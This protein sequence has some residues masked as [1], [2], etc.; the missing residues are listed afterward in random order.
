MAPRHKSFHHK[1]R[2]GCV[3]CKARH[4]KCD[5]GRPGCLRCRKSNRRCGG[6]DLPK[7]WIFE[8]Y[9][10]ND[11]TDGKRQEQ[12]R[13]PKNTLGDSPSTTGARPGEDLALGSPGYVQYLLK[14]YSGERRQ[15]MSLLFH[16]T[17][18]H[19]GPAYIWRMFTDA[20]EHKIWRS[21]F[22]QLMLCE[23]A[24]LEAVFAAVSRTMAATVQPSS[25]VIFDSLEHYNKALMLLRSRIAEPSA[26]YNDA[27]FWSIIALLINDQEREDWHSYG[28]NLGG[29][30]RMIQLRGGAE[31][32][33]SLQDRSYSLYLW[34]ESCYAKHG[35]PNDSTTAD[36]LE[37]PYEAPEFDV[38]PEKALSSLRQYSPAFFQIAKQYSLTCPTICALDMT[39]RWLS[40]HT[41]AEG[42]EVPQDQTKV[43]ATL[44]KTWHILLCRSVPKEMERLVCLGLFALIIGLTPLSLV[45]RYP[46]VLS[47]H[48]LELDGMCITAASED[49]ALWTGLVLAWMPLNVG[50]V[51]KTRWRLLQRVIARRPVGKNWKEARDIAC[52]FYMT[53]SLESQWQECWELAIRKS[54]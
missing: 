36:E 21:K 45:E 30:R 14:N 42:S 2:S 37:G 6:Y 38:P 40:T 50:L 28:V 44:A 26:A 7:T 47:R 17:I 35:D 39:L 12:C 16:Y 53:E 4:V 18:T 48:L 52:Q 51:P 49:C 41:I 46:H 27:V 31:T 3:T 33:R 11:S 10:D 25:D 19:Y 9:C 43:R 20:T 22:V 15:H 32:L 8:P 54:S 24:I 1:V 5:E 23:P 13:A 29:I 34:A